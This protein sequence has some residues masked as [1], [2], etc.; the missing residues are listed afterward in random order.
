MLSSGATPVIIG[1]VTSVYPFSWNH[2]LAPL[3]R[4]A[5]VLMMAVCSLD[6]IQ[7]CLRSS[8]SSVLWYSVIG[9]GSASPTSWNL[10]ACISN[11]PGARLSSAKVPSIMTDDSMPALVADSNSA[12][13]TLPFFTVTWTIP[14]ES[15]RTAN[16]IPPLL[17]VR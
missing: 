9:N 7:R 14:V 10:E 17:L 3:S 16:T 6:L 8:R 12:S 2:S 15:L 5:F 1:G 13:G 4:A 11:P